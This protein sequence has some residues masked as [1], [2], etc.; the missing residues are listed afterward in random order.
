MAATMSCLS[1]A[2][3]KSRTEAGAFL[4]N[5]SDSHTAKKL[6]LYSVQQPFHDKQLLLS[7]EPLI[8]SQKSWN[9]LL[10]CP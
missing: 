1:E 5:L 10:F 2:V 4:A 7:R 8:L 9:W 3:F 6:G